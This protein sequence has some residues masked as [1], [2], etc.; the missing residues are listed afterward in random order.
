M[1]EVKC[2]CLGPTTTATKQTT[3][4]RRLE[5]QFLFFVFIIFSFW[6]GG[7]AMGGRACVWKRDQTD[8]LAGRPGVKR[9]VG[10]GFPQKAKLLRQ[11]DTEAFGNGGK[12]YRSLCARDDFFD[13]KIGRLEELGNSSSSLLKR[14]I[15]FVLM[16]TL[17][18]VLII[19]IFSSFSSY[20][21]LCQFCFFPV[22]GSACLPPPLR[23]HMMPSNR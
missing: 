6:A 13:V 17:N 4:K 16:H 8:G 15:D 5:N 11:K 10:L 3:N 14:T 22:S 2:V 18:E 1:E 21:L 12:G 19:T 9:T 20:C 7:R 23:L